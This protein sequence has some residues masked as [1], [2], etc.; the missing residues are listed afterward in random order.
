[1]LAEV[2]FLYNQNVADMWCM[3]SNGHHADALRGGFED[4]QVSSLRQKD[5]KRMRPGDG[6]GL[7]ALQADER[8][9]RHGGGQVGDGGTWRNGGRMLADAPSPKA[10]D[11]G[12]GQQHRQRRLSRDRCRQRPEQAEGKQPFKWMSLFQDDE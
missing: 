11:S 9:L 12:H 10:A 6:G 4:S 7:A 5:L 8:L 1:M 3:T 2:A